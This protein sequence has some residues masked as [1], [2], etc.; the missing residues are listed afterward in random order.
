MTISETNEN[1]ACL[2]HDIIGIIFL[3]SNGRKLGFLVRLYAI[4]SCKRP[5][6]RVHHR[7][8]AGL[9]TPLNPSAAGARGS[10]HE[11]RFSCAPTGM[12]LLVRAP[13]PWQSPLP[14]GMCRIITWAYGHVAL[15]G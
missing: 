2:Y 15:H 11:S 7:C 10:V 1:L 8:K 13:L 5:S 14:I 6:T 4:D 9:Q 3:L 12:L